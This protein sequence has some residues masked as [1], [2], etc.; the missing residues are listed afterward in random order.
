MLR[1]HTNIHYTSLASSHHGALHGK[2]MKKKGRCFSPSAQ[3]CFIV[4]KKKDVF[5][6]GS[7]M[8]R[9]EQKEGKVFFAFC[10]KEIK[11]FRPHQSKRQHAKVKLQGS[12]ILQG[13][14]PL[15]SLH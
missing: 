3:E 1:I 6:F 5:A 13:N 9:C 10:S 12:S 15:L 4:N 2:L 14:F 11:W 8:L 7:K